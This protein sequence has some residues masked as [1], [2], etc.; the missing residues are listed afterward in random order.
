MLQNPDVK[1]NKLL[2]MP[3]VLFAL[4]GQLSRRMENETA[5]AVLGRATRLFLPSTTD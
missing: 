4:G 1:I 2:G 3:H 5:Q